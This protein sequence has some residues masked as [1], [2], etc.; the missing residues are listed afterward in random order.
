LELFFSGANPAIRSN[1]LLFKEKSKRISTSIGARA[2]IF[3]RMFSVL[4]V[5]LSE[6]EAPFAESLCGASTSLSLTIFV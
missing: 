1:L 6:V 3:I 5:R 2:L 4:F